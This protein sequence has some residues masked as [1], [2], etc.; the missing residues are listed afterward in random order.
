MTK[1]VKKIKK[2]TFKKPRYAICVG[3]AFG[4]LEELTELFFT[5]FVFDYKNDDLKKKNIVYMENDRFLTSIPDV[6]VIFINEDKKEWLKPL[7]AVWRRYNSVL[8]IE[9]DPFADKFLRNEQYKIVIIEKKF[10]I[11]KIA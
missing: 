4:N 7:Q 1:F 6:D 11:W 2:M 9:G 5:V 10:H 3:D 8:V